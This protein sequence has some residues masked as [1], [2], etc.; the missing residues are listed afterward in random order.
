MGSAIYGSHGMFISF[1]CLSEALVEVRVP[2]L[3][4]PC[5]WKHEQLL[6]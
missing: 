4:I 6:H 1:L 5:A 2:G 3:V